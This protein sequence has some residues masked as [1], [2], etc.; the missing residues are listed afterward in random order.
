MIIE[1]KP[2]CFVIIRFMQSK[3]PGINSFLCIKDMFKEPHLKIHNEWDAGPYKSIQNQ[4]IT[5]D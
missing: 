2:L 3:I 1:S 4:V 5:F